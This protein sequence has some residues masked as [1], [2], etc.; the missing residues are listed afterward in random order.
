MWFILMQDII[1]FRLVRRSWMLRE[2]QPIHLTHA[3][4][5]L[6][7]NLDQACSVSIMPKQLNIH[8]NQWSWPETATVMGAQ[9][10]TKRRKHVD[11]YSRGEQSGKKAK[12][13][14]WTSR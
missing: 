14:A 1:S 7:T 4:L 13:D 6:K 8:P 11:P 12:A 9:P 5:D 2:T 3:L 10:K